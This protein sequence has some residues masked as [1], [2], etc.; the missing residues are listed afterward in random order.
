MPYSDH[1]PDLVVPDNKLGREDAVPFREQGV[2]VGY[3]K[4]YKEERYTTTFTV[5]QN[6]PCGNR[7]AQG[8]R[9]HNWCF[10]CMAGFPIWFEDDSESD[11]L[12]IV[13]RAI[14]ST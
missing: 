9:P 8:S 14:V 4:E 7:R 12:N 1:P 3:C 13:D 11:D 5:Q 10:R 2:S 6:R